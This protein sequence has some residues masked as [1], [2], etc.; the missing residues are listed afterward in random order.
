MKVAHHG[1]K[2]STSYEFLSIIKPELSLI[3]CSKNNSGHPHVELLERL[4]DMGSEVVITYES[5]AIQIETDGRRM[6]KSQYLKTMLGT[7]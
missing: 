7:K 4:D 3:S 1:S 5:G 6:R 2:N